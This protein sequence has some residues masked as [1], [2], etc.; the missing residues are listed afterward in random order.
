[1]LVALEAS[2][3]TDPLQRAV[4]TAL[5]HRYEPTERRAVAI[6]ARLLKADP[7]E[8]ALERTALA[9]H[10][11]R[12]GIGPLWALAGDPGAHPS[13]RLRGA[14]ALAALD[15][16]AGQWRAVAPAVVAALRAEDRAAIHR[17]AGL[18]DPARW[19][20]VPALEAASRD[21]AAD[22]PLRATA[23]VA[24]TEIHT[25]LHPDAPALARLLPDAPEEVF[26]AMVHALE[27]LGDNQAATATLDSILSAVTNMPAADDGARDQAA[28]RE[29]RT[30]QALA[31]VGFPDRVWPRLVHRTDPRVRS[32]LIDQLGRLGLGP[33]PLLRRLPQ[34]T[35]AGERQALLLALSEMVSDSSAWS[36]RDRDAAVSATRELFSADPDAGVHS[37]SELLLRRLDRADVIAERLR[38]SAPLTAPDAGR[39]WFIG[40]NGHVFAVTGA[41]EGW[42]GTPAGERNRNAAETL[43]YVR[44][45]R[46]LA[47]ATTETTVGQ[48]REM[49]RDSPG[50]RVPTYAKP[51]DRDP[52]TAMGQVDWYEAVRYCN[53][54]SKR[55][56]IPEDQWCYPE[57]VGPGMTLNE[58]ALDRAGFRLPTEAEWELFCR[59]G[60]TTVRPF[61]SSGELLSRYAWCWL[62][63][64]DLTQPVA[65]LWPN[66]IGLF[67]VIGNQWEWCHDGRAE[68]GRGRST[69]PPGTP[70][71]P[72]ADRPGTQ[73]IL[74]QRDLT[75]PGVETE[76]AQRGGAFDYAP[77]WCR[78]GA[79]GYF[80]VFV[81][82]RY[83]GFRVVRTIGKP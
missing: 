75:Q 20:L 4:A 73:T 76:R 82:D 30:A 43:H 81:D 51:G 29:A 16:A 32:A 13:E 60:T 15:P 5:L 18:L 54:L 80:R 26:P 31:A 37:A 53:W 68:P 33:V 36:G 23:A 57:P 22:G 24:L 77:G 2:P 49:L 11:D 38:A 12:A 52:E 50:L 61:E 25:A 9:A 39:R 44:T 8:L 62:T 46:S 10:P 34:A 58:N 21:A 19:A 71:E 45:G 42:I 66:T 56:G 27:R 64:D 41:L 28:R 17:W 74:G 70:G 40:H 78:S 59:A 79:R 1:M 6:R 63:S 3:D 83:C 48:Y 47:V 67:D 72:A 55:A 7:D 65:R 35:D 69:Y 14:A